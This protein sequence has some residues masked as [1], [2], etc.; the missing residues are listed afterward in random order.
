MTMTI[1]A[2]GLSGFPRPSPAFFSKDEILRRAFFPPSRG[3]VAAAGFG[4]AF[5]L[6]AFYRFRLVFL[7]F[8]HWPRMSKAPVAHNAHVVTAP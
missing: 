3:G 2:L 1:A 7:V 8:L 6:T 5:P 4:R